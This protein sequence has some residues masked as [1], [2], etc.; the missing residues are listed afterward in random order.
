M[1]ESLITQVERQASRIQEVDKLK[2]MLKAVAGVLTKQGVRV[3]ISFGTKGSRPKGRPIRT[4][5]ATRKKI[6]KAK[7]G[8]LFMVEDEEP[9]IDFHDIDF[10][11]EA[12]DYGMV[13]T[14]D[15]V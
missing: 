13:A 11:D 2:A 3:S 12:E 14:R 4:R 8:G 15:E 10:K 6:V 7:D 5:K 1:H 9:D